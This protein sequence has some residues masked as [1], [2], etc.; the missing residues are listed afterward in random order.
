MPIAGIKIRNNHG[1]HEKKAIRSAWSRSKNL[2]KKKV[3]PE[4]RAK[5][6]NK[7]IEARGVLKY[8][9]NSLSNII[10]VLLKYVFIIYP[11]VLTTI[12]LE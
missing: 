7:N 6:T 5:K 8:P 11:T 12:H 2:P 3:I 4:D 10:Y 1:C 9:L